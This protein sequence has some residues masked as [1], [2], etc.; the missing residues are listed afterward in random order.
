VQVTAYIVVSVAAYLL[1]SIPTGFLVA[2]AKGIDIRT[3]GSKNMGATNVFRTLGKW[4]GIFVLLVDGLKGF[5]AAAWLC[6]LVLQQFTVPTNQVLT[7]HVVAGI[8]AVLGHNYT[9]WLWF[10]GGKGIAT[11]AGVYFALAPLS[12]SIALGVWIILF[13]GT[14]YVSVASIAAAAVLPVMVWITK[15]SVLLGVVTTVLC[16]MA[17]YK[18][19][20]NIQRLIA[21]TENR[22]QFKKE[23][24]SA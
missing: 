3:V 4:P 6:D 22:I 19:K 11:T 12:V 20:A 5:A 18:H 15:D 13:I 24:S 16:S 10:K 1:G 23:K 7:V 9:C 14:R 8:F 2:K 17:I 21:G